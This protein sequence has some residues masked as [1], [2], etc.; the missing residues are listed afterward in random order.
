MIVSIII[1]NYNYGNYLHRC[2]RSC[3][4]QTLPVNEFEVILVDDFSK[5]NSHNVVEE[6]RS[7]PNFRYIRNKKNLGVAHSA[8]TAIKRSKGKYFV[9]VDSDDYINKEFANILSLYLEENPK[10]LGVA[11]DYYLINDKEKKFDRFHPKSN[12]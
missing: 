11:C 8:N 10:K 5:D 2:I 7:L 1:T 12:Q 3:L 4:N 9:R 6:Y